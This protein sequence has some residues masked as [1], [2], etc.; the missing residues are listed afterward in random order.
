[1][2]E[3][4]TGL[5]DCICDRGPIKEAQMRVC[6][7]TGACAVAIAVFS[8]TTGHAQADNRAAAAPQ[9]QRAPAQQVTVTGCVQRE[10]DYRKARDAGR[11]GVAGTGLGAGNEFVLTEAAMS[12]AAAGAK[13][14]APAPAATSGSTAAAYELTGANEAKAAQYVGRKVEISGMLKAAEVQS[15]GRAT[16]GPTAGKPPEGIDVVG[17]DL[18]LRELEVSSIREA[19]GSCAA[20]K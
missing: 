19:P 1:V 3:L 14:A 9:E 10:A 2:D 17:R 12:T 16:G 15:S 8:H 20:Q 4:R 11:G 13:E 18:Q 7:S 5:G 6:F